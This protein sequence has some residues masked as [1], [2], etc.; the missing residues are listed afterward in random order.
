MLGSDKAEEHVSS[1]VFEI[2]FEIEVVSSSVK[3]FKVRIVPLMVMYW[4]LTVDF[5]FPTGRIY[6]F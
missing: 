1:G 6:I 3:K 4:R 2:A 5:F